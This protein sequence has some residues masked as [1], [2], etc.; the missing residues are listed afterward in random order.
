MSIYIIY[1]YMYALLQVLTVY[2]MFGRHLMQIPGL[3]A[4]RAAAILD[5]YPT[6][7]A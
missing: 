6:I 3:S 7:T 2:E 1:V 4:E 5:H